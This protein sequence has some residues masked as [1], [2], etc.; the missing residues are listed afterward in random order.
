MPA[1]FATDGFIHCSTPTQALMVA[2]SWFKGQQGLI[3]LVIDPDKLTSELRWEPPSHPPGG[4]G[5]LPPDTERFPHVYGQ[6]NLD[7][8]ARVVDFPPDDTG[9]FALP[10]VT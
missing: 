5:D 2:N 4:E 3:L 8:V 9:T 6:I 7:A 1:D 10:D